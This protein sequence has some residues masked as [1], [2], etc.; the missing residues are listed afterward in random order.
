LILDL[1]EANCPLDESIYVLESLDFYN[2][3]SNSNT[4]VDIS[5]GAGRETSLGEKI[6]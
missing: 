1:L 3:E 5:H 4:E 6:Y 2:S